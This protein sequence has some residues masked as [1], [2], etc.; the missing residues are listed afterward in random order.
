MHRKYER[1][2]RVVGPAR[3]DPHVAGYPCPAKILRTFRLIEAHSA[4]GCLLTVMKSP[5]N[6]RPQTPGI[7]KSFDASG[8]DW[9]ASALKKLS[10]CSQTCRSITNLIALGLGVGCTSATFNPIARLSKWGGV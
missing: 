2:L 8:C 1:L 3:C 6:N 10:G 7:V 4:P 5:R 9:A